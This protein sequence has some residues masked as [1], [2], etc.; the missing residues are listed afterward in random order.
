MKEIE[1]EKISIMLSLTNLEIG[2]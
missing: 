2:C 1:N